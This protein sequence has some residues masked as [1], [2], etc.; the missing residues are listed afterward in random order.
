VADFVYSMATVEEARSIGTRQ[1][2]A[3]LRPLLERCLSVA[4]VA[5]TFADCVENLDCTCIDPPEDRGE[6]SND[7][8]THAQYCY[9][10][11]AALKVDRDVAADLRRELGKEP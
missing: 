11:L 6:D 8:E 7:P 5:G 1:E 9:H 3:R 4:L 2:R 10:Y